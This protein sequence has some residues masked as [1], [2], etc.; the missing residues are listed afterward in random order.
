M[1]NFKLKVF[2]NCFLILGFISFIF[3]FYHSII[4]VPW[5][6]ILVY[7][8]DYLI[9]SKSDFIFQSFANHIVIVPNLF[10]Y[11]SLFIFNGSLKFNAFI[12]LGCY[13]INFIIMNNIIFKKQTNSNYWVLAILFILFFTNYRLNNLS[14]SV[15]GAHYLVGFFSFLA[16]YF[17][18]FAQGPK[19][20]ERINN[21]AAC[22]FFL[23]LSCLTF[24]NG[25]L[26]FL[27]IPFL[28]I[29]KN[30]PKVLSSKN[31]SFTFLV[32]CLCLIFFIVMFLNKFE[33]LK[34]FVL[35]INVL[36]LPFTGILGVT[37]FGKVISYLTLIIFF[38]YLKE[39]F[40]LKK[41]N[42][43]NIFIMGIILYGFFSILLVAFFRYDEY[44]NLDW[45]G[46][47]YGIFNLY[48]YVGIVLFFRQKFNLFHF[49]SRSIKKFKFLFLAIVI[50]WF[51][52]NLFSGKYII[53]RR[54]LFDS[55]AT[56]VISGNVA[57]KDIFY[58]INF[59]PSIDE[60]IEKYQLLIDNNLYNLNN[61]KN[62]TY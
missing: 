32:F 41:Y 44:Q 43:E 4:E 21:L 34:I 2:V 29:I 25:F 22:L 5:G 55:V 53:N 28:Y 15:N 3:S 35:F 36:G 24:S 17:Y 31:L 27:I 33:L 12:Y 62:N 50:F 8:T 7:S 61:Y 10:D 47:R 57:N 46:H 9:L 40:S 59:Y 26:L 6:D 37:F 38:L 45:H 49:S 13:L 39:F 16:I 56:E 14:N 23:I 51:I 11:I 1:I 52:A 20:K 30:Y 18:S 42:S 60:A 48:I 54:V 19:L 58:S